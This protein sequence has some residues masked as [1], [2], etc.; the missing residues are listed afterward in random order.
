MGMERRGE[1]GAGKSGLT[2]VSG[3]GLVNLRSFQKGCGVAP[4]LGMA[5]IIR[6]VMIYVK[7]VDI[8]VPFAR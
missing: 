4:I 8:G 1:L 3:N 6:L 7:I 2:P 5:R